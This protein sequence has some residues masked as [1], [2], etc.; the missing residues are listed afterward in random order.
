[1]E[2]VTILGSGPAGYTAAI[3]SA[4]A[5]LGPLVI[6]GFLPGGQLTTTTEIENFPGFPEGI[7]GTELMQRMRA[8]AERFGARFRGGEVT[9]L[10][11]SGEVPVVDA[12]GE[13]IESRTVII[14]T[15]ASPRY[16]GLESE[17]ALLG[18][19]VSS[20]ATCDGAFFRDVPV[21]V[22]GGGDSAVEEA[23]FLTRFASKVTVIH[24]RDQLRASKV[25]QD[26]ARANP[27][28]EFAWNSVV[29]DILDVEAGKV[30]AVRLR[31]V[32]TGQ[33]RELEVEGVFIAIGHVP[34]TQPF[35]GTVETDER[36]YIVVQGRT[37]QTNVPG[38][39]AAGDVV[40]SAY[41]QAITA[42][43]LGCAAA[44]EAERYLESRGF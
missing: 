28:I 14:A 41:R 9:G 35:A 8:Q 29:D 37:C 11:V 16:L 12:G 24:R 15:G 19:G 23:I 1:M 26:R 44:L 40:D 18:R 34:N 22:V 17:K 20:C 2:K 33:L 10:D 27:K 42:A 36:G 13:R 4:R 38:V 5:N 3:Y 32:K 30:T 21:A 25:M 43:G 6:E 39:F 31:D 7:D